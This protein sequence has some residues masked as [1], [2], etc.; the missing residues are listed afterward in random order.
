M[1]RASSGCRRTKARGTRARVARNRQDAAP[2]IAELREAGFSVESFRE[3]LTK[4]LD[5]R[6]AI[7]LLLAWLPR[8]TNA[9][10]KES[11]VRTL[12]VPFARPIAA[13]PLVEEFRRRTTLPLRCAGQSA[14]RS[15]WSLTTSSR[16]R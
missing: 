15:T 11:I 6:A 12:S 1:T 3:L 4:K 14:T 13:R 5:F 10:V 9:D 2:I 8:V 16:T 7:P